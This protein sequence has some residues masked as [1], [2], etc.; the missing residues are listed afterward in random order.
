MKSRQIIVTE[1]GSQSLFI[2]ELNEHYHSVHGAIQESK[3]VYIDAALS[4]CEKDT[5]NVFEMGFGTG[6]NAL[7]TYQYALHHEKKINYFTIEKYPLSESE[8]KILNY[9]SIINLPEKGVLHKLHSAPIGTDTKIT[10][11]FSFT[12]YHTDIKTLSCSF[13][14]DVCYYDAFAPDIQPDLWSSEIFL[15]IYQAM[16][17]GGVLSTYS[18]KGQVKRNLIKAG[19]TIEKLKG[20]P[21]KREIL[22]AWKK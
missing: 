8:Y 16:N 5:I 19:F 10:N 22:R 21:G 12:K 14:I 6:L 1:D 18:A 20:P 17:P 9:E 7:L 3:H 2:P 11:S 15:E 4:T 13:P